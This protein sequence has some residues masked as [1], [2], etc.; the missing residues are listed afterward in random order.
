MFGTPD[1]KQNFASVDENN[2]LRENSNLRNSNFYT[3]NQQNTM[4]ND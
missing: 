3:F 1:R 2:D 4:G